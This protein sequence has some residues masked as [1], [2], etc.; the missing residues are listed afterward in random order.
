MTEPNWNGRWLRDGVT[1]ISK[2]QAR[3]EFGLSKKQFV[4]LLTKVYK[5]KLQ[6]RT[7]ELQNERY[8]NSFTVYSVEDLRQVLGLNQPQPVTNAR[9]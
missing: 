6:L 8:G 9:E 4:A 2:T 3:K 7:K 5:E 1:Y